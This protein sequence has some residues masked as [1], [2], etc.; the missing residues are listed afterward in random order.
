MKKVI[1]MLMVIVLLMM[2]T[3]SFAASPVNGGSNGGTG[4][5]LSSVT[6]FKFEHKRNGIGCGN[7]P[8]YSAPYEGAYRA[9][10]G[11]ASVDTDHSLDIGG[12]NSSGWLLVR[13]ETNKGATRVGWIPPRYVRGVKS[14]MYPHFSYIAQT[15]TSYT[16][17]TD[18][19]LAPYNPQ[20]FF[21]QLE[22]GETYYI[23]GRYNYYGTE[24]W[25]IEFYLNGQ[26]ANG[27]IPV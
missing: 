13:Y 4:A 16:Y 25:F 5:S 1:S 9:A 11:K 23:I 6:P 18:D 21:A 10:N 3:V 14:S 15:A 22:P 20:S 26:L 24:L 12:F 19:N 17:V 8:V 27:F 2:S 7:C